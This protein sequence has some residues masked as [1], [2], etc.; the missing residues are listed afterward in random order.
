MRNGLILLGLLVIASLADA[1]DFDIGGT[2]T[3]SFRDLALLPTRLT[4]YHQHEDAATASYTCCKVRQ[5]KE[6]QAAI[7]ANAAFLN[8]FS[9]TPYADDTYMHYAYVS[10]FRPESFRNEEW[11]YRCLVQM[12]PDSDLADDGAWMLGN[13]YR[14]DYD[15]ERAIKVYEH[16]VKQWPQSTWAD[17]ALMALVEEYTHIE[18]TREALDALNQLAY[19]Y[20][21]SEF[22][23]R[24][25]TILSQKYMEVQ[26][27][28]SAIN[29]CSD[30]I[31]DFRYCDCADD[32]QMRIAEC[33]R[34]MNRLPEALDA[35]EK[36][37]KDW[38]GSDLTNQAMREA[39]NLVQRLNP[40]RAPE[41]LDLYDTLAW[42]PAKD[43]KELWNGE[44]KHY[45]NN[46]MHEMAVAKFREFI[47]K[48]PGND[49]WDDAWYEI[50]QTYLRQEFLFNEINKASGPEDLD[51]LKEDYQASTGDQ[52]P[53]PAD[54][55]LSALDKATEAFAYIAN[56]LKGSCLQCNALGMVA[57]CYTPYGDIDTGPVTGD[58]AYTHQEIVI[59]FP[60][61]S[62]RLPFFTDGA[63][64]VF[65]F[66]KLMSFYADE[67]NW[68]TA[69]EIYPELSAEYPGVFPVGLEQDKDA[70]YELMKLYNLKVSF[71]YSEIN[72]HIK[73]AI[74]V[75]DLIPEAHYFQAAMLMGQGEYAR[76]AELLAPLAEMQGHDLA[77]PALYLYAQANIRLG[78]WDEARAAF[79]SLA[80]DFKDCGLSDDARICWEQFQ[81]AATN[82]GKYD[83]TEITRKVYEQFG[84]VPA[85]M[86]VFIGDGCVVLAPFTRAPLMRMYNMPN[87]WDEAQRVLK[88]W[89]G[90]EKAERVVIVVDR[91]CASTQGNPF[92]VPGCQIKDPPQWGMGLVN[93]A[94]NVL[95]EAVPFLRE[96]QDLL[97]GVAE[98]AAASLQYDLV[99]ETRD[100]IGSAAAVKLPQEEVVRARERALKSLDEYVIQ[101]EDASLNRNVVAG[102]MYA[103]LDS[104]GF[105]KSRM[106]DREPYRSF[107]AALRDA[108]TK[109]SSNETFARAV[110]A[111]FGD[112]CDQ[113]L[114]DWRLPVTTV[115]ASSQAREVK[116]GMIR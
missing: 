15:H 80:V 10:S 93:I 105:S 74:G 17:D 87:V 75:S 25:L 28:Q 43:A 34:L 57:R 53:V 96:N 45:Q 47:E 26:D 32:A 68:E 73:Y 110:K 91:G 19:D 5:E 9:G 22:C 65:S 89:T 48:F 116:I 46:G 66:C 99:T 38:Y 72:H 50:G 76:A 114:K 54:G 20:P 42:N 108:P 24:A 56:N 64:P 33:Y 67:K 23:S 107:F 59:H 97:G 51:R 61:N 98:F 41:E 35:Y 109:G 88:D 39:N 16:I 31:R 18:A 37:I 62:T 112:G 81:D 111:T 30:L 36:L 2:I 58:A 103:L 84:I 86:D 6:I 44:A 12:F 71:A 40:G 49:L 27:Y 82:P 83:M 8:R 4:Y 77:A 102:M 63:V 100:A 92:K 11:G 115:E 79:E 21:K 14:K 3:S 78:L 55:S 90:A 101:G 95:G 94:S 69:R 70:F 106:I 60:F 1:Q 29:A 85:N 13:L 7:V 113:Q 52:G 104:N